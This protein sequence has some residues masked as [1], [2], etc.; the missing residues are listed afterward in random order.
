MRWQNRRERTQRRT[1]DDVPLDDA[2]PGLLA[3]GLGAG[4]AGGADFGSDFS[5][6]SD[7][8]DFSALGAD[9]DLSAGASADFFSSTAD[10]TAAVSVLR[11]S[12]TYQP[13]PLKTMPTG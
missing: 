12:V 13:L 8:S 1:Y 4:A 10:G 2:L 6:R 7:F 3:A 5:L 11:L 9:S